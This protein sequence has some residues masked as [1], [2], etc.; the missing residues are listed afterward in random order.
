MPVALAYF[1]LALL[2]V[3][4]ALEV[5]ALARS[6]NSRLLAHLADLFKQEGRL[7]REENDS[8]ARRGRE[9]VSAAIVQLD[10]RLQT[11]LDALRTGHADA[12]AKLRTEVTANLNEIR[13]TL[14]Q[15]LQ[16]LQA[17]IATS[18]NL[19]ADRGAAAQDSLRKTVE[20]KLEALRDSVETKLETIRQD[21]A[22]R[23]EQMRA[24]VE[25]KLQGTLEARLGESFR[26]VSQQLEVVHQ[27]L[28]E[29]RQLAEGVGD[30]KR[31]MSN[32]KA[33]GTWGEVQL[34]ALLEEMLAPSQFQ[35]NV[36][37]G[38]RDGQV[39]FAVKLPGRG[40]EGDAPVWLPLDSKFPIEDYRRLSEALDRNDAAAADAAAKALEARVAE[41]AKTIC[42]KYIHPP[43]TTDFAILF[44]PSE[45]LFAEIIRKPDLPEM[46]QRK[47]HV[48][49]AGPATL[50]ALLLSLQAG[51]RSLAVQQRSAE[52]WK[53]L[54][55]VKTQFSEFGA[56]LD[57]VKK[58]LE[59]AGNKIDD[60][61]RQSRKISRALS[62][63]E[64]LPA[65]EAA[66]LLDEADAPR[67]L[68][69]AAGDAE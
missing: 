50:S 7:L 34:G 52:V 8:A 59:Q 48:M 60:A 45:G 38:P 32:V 17:E 9:E 37:L 3:V 64:S 33:R 13:A 22:M 39:E 20:Q 11:Q 6:G 53:I 29:M 66:P 28:G 1:V 68:A 67:A 16:R 25:E 54:G 43:Q 42:E 61:A 69:A 65:A 30:L 36:S 56:L 51:F 49:I 12:G 21:N 63:V 18:L 14:D 15:R 23:L 26:Q 19:I 41:C 57:G 27:G 31:V 35:R 2:L 46:V 62:E 24:T 55:A 5:F 44:L 10:G 47:F 4:V 40:C 58:K